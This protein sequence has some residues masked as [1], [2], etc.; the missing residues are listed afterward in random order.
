M[1]NVTKCLFGV[2]MNAIKIAENPVQ[3]RKTK[4][5]QIRHHFL[6]DH[7]LKDDIFIDHVKTEECYLLSTALDFPEEERMMQ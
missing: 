6:R 7:V 3:H 5:I 1:S 2:T 4:H